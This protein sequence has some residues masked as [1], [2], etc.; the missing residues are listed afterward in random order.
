[1]LERELLRLLDD[2]CDKW[3][4]EMT[5]SQLK[6]YLT[7]LR[8]TLRTGVKDRQISCTELMQLTNTSPACVKNA[9]R[10]LAK[11]NLVEW[12]EIHST[13]GSNEANLYTV[14]MPE[15]MNV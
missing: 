2:L 1:M 7:I 9:K 3:L 11:Q 5:H 8:K 6:L 13:C 10:Y 14:V 15:N 12:Q 4:T